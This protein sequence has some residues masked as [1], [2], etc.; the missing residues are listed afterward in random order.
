M[1]FYDRTLIFF[2]GGFAR[3]VVEESIHL[4]GVT[5][6]GVLAP[7]IGADYQATDDT[8]IRFT[9][10]L[11][12]PEKEAFQ[13]DEAYGWE[14]DAGLT[15]EFYTDQQLFLEAGFLQYGDYWKERWGYR[16]DPSVKAAGGIHLFF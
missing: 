2:D 7:G 9:A 1:P 10:A 15:Y 8:V 6:G 16:P 11:L 3:Y 12:F 14:T 13:L 5:W 4:G